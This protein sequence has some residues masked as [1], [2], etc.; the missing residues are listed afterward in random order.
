[1]PGTKS[2]IFLDKGFGVLYIKN[3]VPDY[4]YFVRNMD[5]TPNEPAYSIGGERMAE[6]KYG[7]I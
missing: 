4:N 5:N 1:L 3:T 7:N 2:E 6:T